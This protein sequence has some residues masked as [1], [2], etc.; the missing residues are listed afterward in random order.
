MASAA[1]PQPPNSRSLARLRESLL[2]DEEP[3]GNV[4]HRS[5]ADDAVIQGTAILDLAG[6][7][8]RQRLREIDQVGHRRL[9]IFPICRCTREERVP[10]RRE[11][12]QDDKTIA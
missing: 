7:V 12:N 4:H 5:F 6:R 11:P 1:A 9:G 10:E 3:W 2:E 8:Q